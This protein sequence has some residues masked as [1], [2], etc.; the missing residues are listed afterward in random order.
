MY[1]LLVFIFDVVKDV[2]YL[3]LMICFADLIFIEI[4]SEQFNPVNKYLDV[5]LLKAGDIG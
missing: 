5:V 4:L 3:Y 2:K 1:L